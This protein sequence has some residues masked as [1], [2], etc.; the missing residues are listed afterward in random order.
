MGRPVVH[1]E[2]GVA[3]AARS[4]DFYAEL[5]GWRIQVDD[6]GYGLID[7]DAGSGINGGI[8][9]K[10]E[11]VPTYVTIYVGVDDLDPFLERAEKLGG[12]TVV[13]PMPVGE[14]GSFAMFADPDGNVIGL[15]QE[16]PST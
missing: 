12:K 2:I 13:E 8:M 3:E 4:R 6:S 7:T 9:Q 14:M 11:G 10:P 16:E 15:F 1:F 5:F